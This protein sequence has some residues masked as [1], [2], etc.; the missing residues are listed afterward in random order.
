MTSSEGQH[1]IHEW[2]CLGAK[3]L[4]GGGLDTCW[5]WGLPIPGQKMQNGGV[6]TAQTPT[7]Q[8]LGGYSPY[9]QT[10]RFAPT[11]TH[12]R[13][14]PRQPVQARG[15][16][17]SCGQ[18]PQGRSPEGSRNLQTGIPAAGPPPPHRMCTRTVDHARDRRTRT[19][20]SKKREKPRLTLGCC[21]F[22]E[23]SFGE[24]CL[25]WCRVYWVDEGMRVVIFNGNKLLKQPLRQTVH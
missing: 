11:C 9:G 8:G 13:V 16:A 22:M 10:T 19:C 18:G 7:A 17:H 4:R 15:R 23:G 5:L 3:L 25:G 12:V 24:D 20:R 1:E 14:L 6:Q 2:C 21:G